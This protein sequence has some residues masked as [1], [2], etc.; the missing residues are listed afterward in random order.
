MPHWEILIFM[1]II[2]LYSP[3]FS[4]SCITEMEKVQPTNLSTLESTDNEDEHS[5]C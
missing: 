4:V 5:A 3:D 1:A 2:L